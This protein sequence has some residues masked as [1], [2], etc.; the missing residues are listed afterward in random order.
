MTFNAYRN[1]GKLR[2][3]NFNTPKPD[4]RIIE[5]ADCRRRGYLL[6]NK[7]L[8]T[9]AYAKVKL[10]RVT[11]KKLA[12]NSRL[13]ED[14]RK[15]GHDMVAVKI[16]TKKEA[17]TEYLT[18]FMP[19]ELESLKAVQTH[20]NIIFL[21]E[22]FRT[23]HRIYMVIEYAPNGDL[24]S[25]INECVVQTG[26]ATSEDDARDLF[27]MICCG[28][29]HC[30][31]LNIVHRDL[32]CENILLSAQDQV[33]ISDFGFSCRFPTNRCN[34]LS[35]FCGSYAY[36]APEIL[37]A[38]SYDG[39]LA[40][41]WS[42][43]I[44]LYAMVNGKLPFH[45]QDLRNLIEQTRQRLLFQP[46]VS[47]EC[48]DLI[49]K[50]LRQRPLTRLRMRDIQNHA[51]LRMTRPKATLEDKELRNVLDDF[52]NLDAPDEE[53]EYVI[54]RDSKENILKEPKLMLMA[55]GKTVRKHEHGKDQMPRADLQLPTSILK[56]PPSSDTREARVEATRQPRQDS[57]TTKRHEH[58]KNI[59]RRILR[60][61]SRAGQL[62]IHN[63]ENSERVFL[64][65]T[66]TKSPDRKATIK[67]ARNSA[68]DRDW[69]RKEH[70]HNLKTE[71][72]KYDIQSKNATTLSEWGSPAY[73]GMDGDAVVITD[74][75]G[76]DEPSSD[77]TVTLVPVQH[78]TVKSWEKGKERST[79]C[80]RLGTTPK[81]RHCEDE[82]STPTLEFVTTP[83]SG[84]ATTPSGKSPTRGTVTSLPT[85]SPP[86]KIQPHPL[87][88]GAKNVRQKLT[89]DFG[90]GVSCSSR[91][92]E[93]DPRRDV[94]ER[95]T[96]ISVSP[97]CGKTVTFDFEPKKRLK[98]R[99]VSRN[100]RGQDE[101]QLRT[102]ELI[103]HLSNLPVLRKFKP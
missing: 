15:K 56:K 87:T 42:L 59:Y 4:P 46:W 80:Y 10:A 70:H 37:M 65:R 19:R 79:I 100:M 68:R 75:Y 1:Q 101:S 98:K 40:D 99:G 50:M 69:K 90:T 18:K 54:P 35:T 20:E 11:E 27:R 102:S 7:T 9:G 28:V 83:V 57:P 44:I 53:P 71:V 49:K 77:E 17:P 58:I 82:E 63:G 48:A 14:L 34:M 76:D 38:K 92:S 66:Q 52:D 22:I 23:D 61:G 64:Q 95:W 6:T 85:P 30:H 12:R 31:Q 8:G 3:F 72:H 43:G 97:P 29:N 89:A 73:N 60:P 21:Y 32:K 33:K 96:A 93:R 47:R 74:E 78:Q 86:P 94:D 16:I 91:I 36:A 25:Y 13:R 41:I 84:K 39:K 26:R 62:L 2:S 51:W 81:A 45:D 5:Q 67:N 55:N 88:A 24:L 103:D